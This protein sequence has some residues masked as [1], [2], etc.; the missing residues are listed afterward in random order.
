MFMS[1]GLVPDQPESEHHR[2]GLTIAGLGA[3]GMLGLAFKLVHD[4]R[5]AERRA[6]QQDPAQSPPDE[7][8]TGLL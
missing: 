7:T 3:M 2:K 5:A 8:P 4:A 1:E 6:V